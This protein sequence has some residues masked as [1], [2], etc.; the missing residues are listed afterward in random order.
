M[1]AS[2]IG[3]AV[4]GQAGGPTAVINQSLYGVIQ[5]TH[6][7]EHID[8]LLGARHGV[9]GI[10][11]EQFL[12]LR[13]QPT[14]MLDLVA[15]TPGASLGSIIKTTVYLADLDDFAKVNAI[16]AEFFDSDPPARATVEVS[17]LP[18][19]AQVR[20]TPWPGA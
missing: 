7:S 18:A 2:F 11:N 3:N 6:K 10:I 9:R 16:Y 15:Q 19:G 5:E 17:R 20:S 12:D 1:A 8:Q 14:Q 4:I 13:R